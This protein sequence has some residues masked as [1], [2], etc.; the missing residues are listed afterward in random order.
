MASLNEITGTLG[1][2]RAAHLLR[3]TTFGATI[4]EIDQ[5]AG[6]TATAALTLLLDDS[7]A[8]PSPPLDTATGATW[9]DPTGVA[10]PAHAVEDTNSEQDDLFGFFQSW[11][12]DVMRQA[13]LT[14]KERITWFFHTHLPARWTEINSSEAIYYQNRLFRYYAYGSFKDLFKK[15]CVDNA[16]LR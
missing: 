5:F 1:R 4:S 13:P 11:H 10:G 2:S 16:M 14:L 15:I 3:R 8:D 12:M 9:V 6:L 7:A